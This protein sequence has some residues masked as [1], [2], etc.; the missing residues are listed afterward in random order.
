MYPGT[1][2]RTHGDRKETSPAMNA[3]NTDTPI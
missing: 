3:A 2:G 1:R